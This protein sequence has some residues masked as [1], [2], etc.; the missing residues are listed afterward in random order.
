MINFLLAASTPI[1]K[2]EI[3]IENLISKEYD[4]KKLL[5]KN[6]LAEIT[7]EYKL[8]DLP[9]NNGDVEEISMKDFK[10]KKEAYKQNLTF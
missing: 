10:Q 4:Q 1:P 8:E 6:L 3:K 9:K 7:L 5:I 2:S